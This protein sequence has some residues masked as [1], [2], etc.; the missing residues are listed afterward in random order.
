MEEQEYDLD[1][2]YE[3][4]LEESEDAYLAQGESLILMCLQQL[5]RSGV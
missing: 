5:K 1:P 3:E 2:I 4:Y